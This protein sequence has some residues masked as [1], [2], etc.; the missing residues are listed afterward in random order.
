MNIGSIGSSYSYGVNRTERP[1]GP[2]PSPE[3]FASKLIKDL[4]TDADGAL[5]AAEISASDHPRLSKLMEA[6]DSD[7]DGLVTES[8]LVSHAEE[9]AKAFADR[10]QLPPPSLSS[11]SE[12]DFSSL[13]KSLNEAAS[14]YRNSASSSSFASEGTGFS[15]ALQ[16]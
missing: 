8:E 9:R 10:S 5:S 12:V 3:D 2:P 15:L 1:Q 7:G 13:L 14:A 4:D 16:G 6:A 11:S